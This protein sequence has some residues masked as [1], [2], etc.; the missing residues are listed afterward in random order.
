MRVNSPVSDLQFSVVE[1]LSGVAPAESL[2][3]AWADEQQ[4]PTGERPSPLSTRTMFHVENAWGTNSSRIM[5]GVVPSWLSDA[6]VVLF[7]AEG[8]TDPSGRLVHAVEVPTFADPAGSG[9]RLYLVVTDPRVPPNQGPVEGVVFASPDGTFLDAEG[10]C[11]TVPQLCT[12][13][14]ADGLDLRSELRNALTR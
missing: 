14:R 2:V 12:G 1:S 9:G 7:S 3:I 13:V 5:A 4:A 11:A 10:K 8:V 6:H